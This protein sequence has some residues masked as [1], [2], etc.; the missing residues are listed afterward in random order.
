MTIKTEEGSII[1][2]LSKRI[3]EAQRPIRILDQVKWDDTVKREFFRHKAK[4]LPNVDLHYYEKH[5]LPFEPN[6]K[7]EEFRG[8]L[9]DAYN[10]LGEY[11]PVTRLIKRQCYEYMRAVR[12]LEA[13]GTP[14]FNE[15]SKELYGSPDDVFYVGGPR[16]S[17][18]GS[19]LFDLLTTLD[20]QLV[21]DLDIPKYSPHEA[22]TLLQSRLNAF[23]TQDKIKVLINDNM[24]ADAAAGF[25][26]IKLSKKAKFTDRELK[27]LEVHEGWVHL[28]TTINGKL[29]PYCYFLSKGGPSC[30]VVQEGL[31]VLTE[32]ITFSSYP[33]RMRKITNRVIAIDKATRGADF[34]DIFRY[35]IECGLSQDDAYKQCV[36]VFRGS[37]PNGEPFT[38]DLAY[39]KGFV[40]LYNFLCYAISERRVDVV[41]ILFAGKLS[42]DDVPLLLELKAEGLLSEPRYMPPQFRDLAALSVWLGFSLYLDQF[43]FSEIQRNFRFLLA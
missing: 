15:M 12:M 28:G 19:V 16:L 5:P 32:V 7:I 22:K 21:S 37:L 23:F 40:L 2:A 33:A 20:V 6:D 17:E 14:V 18:M 10:Q 24:I 11:S 31:A 39:A 41:P 42:L 27:Y 4:R 34:M 13:R 26:K 30:A 38:K 36:R 43:D 8:I 29:Q 35:F 9:R 25:D 3:V 1:K